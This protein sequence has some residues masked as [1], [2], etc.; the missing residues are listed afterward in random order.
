MKECLFAGETGW[1]FSVIQ[2][3]YNA[4]R[5]AFN[6]NFNGRGK[7]ATKTSQL[8][9]GWQVADCANVQGAWVVHKTRDKEAWRFARADGQHVVGISLEGLRFGVGQ[10]QTVTVKW[11]VVAV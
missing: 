2:S 6:S 10:N 4:R 5:V 1:D 8:F 3:I 9:F 7:G 11:A